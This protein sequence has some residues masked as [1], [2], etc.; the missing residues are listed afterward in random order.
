MKIRPTGILI[1]DNKILLLDQNVNSKRKWSLPGGS[2]EN[3]ETIE[4]CLKR[5]MREE[6]GLD[7]KIIKLLYVN[8]F[9][10]NNTYV[11][12]ITFLVEK[13]GGSLGKTTDIDTEEIRNVKMVPIEDLEKI[14]FNTTFADLVKNNFPDAGNYKGLKSNIGL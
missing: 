2:L 3:G 11:L 12:H 9:F 8:D 13:I 5:E 6:T 4:D 7:V 14:G 1:N 10:R